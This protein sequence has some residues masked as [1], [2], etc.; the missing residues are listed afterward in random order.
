[1]HTEIHVSQT[2][3]KMYM[4]E[5]AQERMKSYTSYLL[6][7]LLATN[8]ATAAVQFQGLKDQT[9]QAE[10]IKGDYSHL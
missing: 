9:N 7:A 5:N 2:G 6:G 10:M 1:M 8:D 4:T 3:E